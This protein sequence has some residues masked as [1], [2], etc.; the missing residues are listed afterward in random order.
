MPAP[1]SA[2]VWWPPIA[3][4]LVALGPD[5]APGW[6]A[7]AGIVLA[8]VGLLGSVVPR[9]QRPAAPGSPDL[10]YLGQVPAAAPVTD[11]PVSS[12]PDPIGPLPALADRAVELTPVSR[13]QAA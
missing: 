7:L 4:I 2:L 1:L 9:R 5:A 6:I 11:G 8:A 12:A 13:P 3:L 10:L